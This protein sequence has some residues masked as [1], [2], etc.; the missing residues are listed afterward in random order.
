M[1]MSESERESMNWATGFAIYGGHDPEMNFLSEHDL[2]VGVET[3]IG[4]GCSINFGMMS[5]Q[6]VCSIHRGQMQATKI[7]ETINEAF[8]AAVVK[9]NNDFQGALRGGL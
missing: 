7:G 9:F 2:V 8:C 5:G 3:V 6:Y 4:F 1:G